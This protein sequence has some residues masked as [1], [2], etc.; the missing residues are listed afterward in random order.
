LGFEKNERA[1]IS[2]KERDA[3]RMVA[4]DLLGLTTEQLQNTVAEGVLMEVCYGK[5]S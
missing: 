4:K 1:N 3:L 2:E 5:E